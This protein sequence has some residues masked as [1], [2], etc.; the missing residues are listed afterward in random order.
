M[1]PSELFMLICDL[2]YFLVYRN[3]NQLFSKWIGNGGKAGP[4]T[5]WFTFQAV[6]NVW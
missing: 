5:R 4:L 2:P 1:L 6:L 3:E